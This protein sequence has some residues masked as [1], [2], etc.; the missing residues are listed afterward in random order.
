MIAT[1]N[2]GSSIDSAIGRVVRALPERSW[3]FSAPAKIN[4]RL[5]VTGR[6]GDGYHYLSMLNMSCSLRDELSV[7]LR[8]Q[9]GISVAVDLASLA[10]M[11]QADNLVAKAYREFWR[12][13]GCAEDGPGLAVSIAKRIPVGGGLGGGSS[14]AGAMLRFLA[15]TFGEV[16]KDH[17]SLAND[18]FEARVM[19]AALACGA[20]VPYAYRGGV[21]WVTGIGEQVTPL[22]IARVWEGPVLISVPA[23]PVPT[24]EFYRAYR[25]RHPRVESSPDRLMEECSQQVSE[26]DLRELA[27]NDFEEVARELV[28]EV[29]QALTLAREF[30]SITTMTGSGSAI[31]SLVDAGGESAAIEQ[32]MRKAVAS[33]VVVHQV[34]L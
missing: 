12:V 8:E 13:F 11:P 14:D 26:V 33:G 1:G 15:A 22:P 2:T 29:G 27:R 23:K 32:Y 17:L 31:V 5:K 25:E 20:D 3:S 34:S 28:P 30:F 10:T 18:D 21:S 19:G 16:I 7:S 9:P 4:L 6:R 24:V